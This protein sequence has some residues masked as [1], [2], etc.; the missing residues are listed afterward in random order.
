MLQWD[1]SSAILTTPFQTTPYII[2]AKT[3]VPVIINFRIFLPH[4]DL[5]YLNNQT[6]KS[7]TEPRSRS[8]GHAIIYCLMHLRQHTK[9][10]LAERP[11]PSPACA[12]V[13]RASGSPPQAPPSPA[14]IFAAALPPARQKG[15]ASARQLASHKTGKADAPVFSRTPTVPQSRRAW[16]WPPRGGRAQR[17]YLHVYPRVYPLSNLLQV[18][19]LRLRA[20]FLM[21]QIVLARG[22]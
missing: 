9:A 19:H 21:Q 8:N 6:K 11:A 16:R 15:T 17:Q 20:R 4:G 22:D 2:F 5:S 18:V 1:T 3:S 14:G 7:V 13:R 12:I 10:F